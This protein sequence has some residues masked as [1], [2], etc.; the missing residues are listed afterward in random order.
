M[1]R[2]RAYKRRIIR[3]SVTGRRNEIIF[4]TGASYRTNRR[5]IHM[6]ALGG[7]GIEKPWRHEDLK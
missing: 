4:I 2:S 6:P 7:K 3:N 5:W 1:H